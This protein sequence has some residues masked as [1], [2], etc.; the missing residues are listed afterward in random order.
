MRGM[1]VADRLAADGWS[2]GVINARFA[3]PLDRAL[4][5]DQARGK[6]LV[7]TLEESVATGGFGSAVLEALTASGARRRDAA[8]AGQ[9]HR[10]GRAITSSTTARSAICADTCASTCEGIAE[11]VREAHR[12]AVDIGLGR[13]SIRSRHRAA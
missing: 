11:Q 4:I 8:R 9:D 3:K 2:V 7:V 6:K 1:E 12:G 13:R 10:P 5:L